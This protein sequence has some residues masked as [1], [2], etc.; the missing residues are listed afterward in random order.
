MI[1]SE[2]FKE[3][4]KIKMWLALINIGVLI[5]EVSKNSW[6]FYWFANSTKVIWKCILSSNFNSIDLICLNFTNLVE[7]SKFLIQTLLYT[8]AVHKFSTIRTVEI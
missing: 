1:L 3:I 4:D 2:L 7:C 5:V 6:R 8:C